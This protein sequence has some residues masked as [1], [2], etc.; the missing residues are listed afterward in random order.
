MK[1]AL[2][3][4]T[5]FILVF[6]SCELETGY[7]DP[8]MTRISVSE[9]DTLHVVGGVWISPKQKTKNAGDDFKLKVF[10]NTG[11]HQLGAISLQIAYNPQVIQPD[12]SI[13]DNGVESNVFV[14]PDGGFAVNILP[15]SPTESR[16]FIAGFHGLGLSA[17][18]QIK[19]FT[20]NWTG[21]AAG[22][23]DVTPFILTLISNQFLTIGTPTE[24]PGS[25]TIQ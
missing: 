7:N 14:Y 1:Q 13:G 3:F 10:A 2:I 20:L 15:I 24:Y 4:F 12:V 22:Q 18:T 21:T 23:T 5:L 17:S 11:T 6:S 8:G 16:L 25:V 9:C 19:L